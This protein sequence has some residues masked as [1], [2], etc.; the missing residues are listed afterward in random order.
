[1]K[2]RNIKSE[3]DFVN[4]A[5]S[6][7][8]PDVKG[9]QR[10]YKAISASLTE[11]HID[12]LDEVIKAAAMTGHVGITRSDVIKAAIEIF[13]EKDVEQKLKIILSNK[14]K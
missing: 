14:E 7:P 4:G 11:S 1:M 12:L 8:K 10:N 13:S 5:T 9:R 3:S 2:N 6:L